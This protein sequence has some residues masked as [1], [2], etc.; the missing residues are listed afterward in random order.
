MGGSAEGFA[1]PSGCR[2]DRDLERF[3]KRNLRA[4]CSALDMEV[5]KAPCNSTFL[6]LFERVEL[7]QLI[8]NGK[9]LR[10]SAAQPDGGDGTTRYGLRPTASMSPR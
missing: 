9:T 10:T 8:C 5:P 4:Y 6:Y 7:S 3:A 1:I 2:S